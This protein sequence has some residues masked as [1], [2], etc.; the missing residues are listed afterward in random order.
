MKTKFFIYITFKG[1]VYKIKD[2]NSLLFTL[3]EE[4]DFTAGI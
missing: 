3:L 1:R 2:N 4:I